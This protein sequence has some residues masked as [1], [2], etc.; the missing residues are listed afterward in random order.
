MLFPPAVAS[1]SAEHDL[2]S[3]W[4]LR[5]PRVAD[6]SKLNA[7]QDSADESDSTRKNKS[8]SVSSRLQLQ[9]NPIHLPKA[10]ESA[11]QT[12]CFKPALK[13]QWRLLVWNRPRCHDGCVVLVQNNPVLYC[14]FWLHPS[15]TPTFFYCKNVSKEGLKTCNNSTIL[16]LNIYLF[17]SKSDSMCSTRIPL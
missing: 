9:R 7:P 11:L 17:K 2:H 8:W 12:L 15:F 16:R 13:K 14:Y 10:V 1:S 5:V 6:D 4:A 3:N